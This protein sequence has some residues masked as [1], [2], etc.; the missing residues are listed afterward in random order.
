MGTA[1]DKL[2]AVLNSKNAIKNK[3]NLADDLP[4]SQYAEN[5]NTA[6]GGIVIPGNFNPASSADVWWNKQFFNCRG[7]LQSGVFEDG[8]FKSVYM[9]NI[10]GKIPEKYYFLWGW[11]KSPDDDDLDYSPYI[12]VV[13]MP[14]GDRTFKAERKSDGNSFWWELYDAD[15]GTVFFRSKARSASHEIWEITDDDDWEGIPDDLQGVTTYFETSLRISYAP[16]SSFYLCSYVNRNYFSYNTIVVSGMPTAPF[17]GCTYVNEETWETADVP[18]DVAARDP[19]GTYTLQNP[20]EAVNSWYWLSENGCV[21]DHWNMAMGQPIIYPG[22]DYK[23]TNKYIYVESMAGEIP[24]YPVPDDY[25]SYSW[26]YCSGSGSD[27]VV[28]GGSVSAPKPPEVEKYWEGYKL[29]AD[30]NGKYNL[31]PDKTKL[32]YGDYMPVAGRIYDAAAT[33]EITNAD[34]TEDALWAC[35]RN[36]TSAE[37][38]DWV[39]SST[40]VY[41]N[42]AA[43]LAFDGNI[44][45]SAWINSGD[46]WWIMWQNK[47]QKVLLQ[48]IKIALDD[49]Y[50]LNKEAFL[51]GSNDGTEWVDIVTP[52]NIITGSDSGYENGVNTV[53]IK[54]PGNGTPYSYYRLGSNYNTGS[55]SIIYTIEA[56][57]QIPREVPK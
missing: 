25:S 8:V 49:N 45:T 21:I 39:V 29:E 14:D 36:M 16:P 44:N 54:I 40:S 31:S 47:T 43:Y 38:D 41:D 1:A 10:N 28:D 7:E 13:S 33:L 46:E 3:F 9:A 23:N 17:V 24:Q 27:T 2:Q 6:P 18:E 15:V 37:N 11:Y 57:A 48:Q 20:D 35:P 12:R 53:T 50:I 56:Y 26:T 52:G 34:F 22:K 32:T 5:I 19:N 55:Y 4:F 42:R 30:E 51:Q